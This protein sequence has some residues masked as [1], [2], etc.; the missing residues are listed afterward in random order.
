MKLYCILICLFFGTS[1]SAQNLNFIF[2]GQVTNFDTGKKE[3]GVTIEVNQ[4]GRT[5]SSSQTASNG[6][7]SAQALLPAKGNFEIIF[8]KAG[9]I[10]KKIQFNY[11][12]FD[13]SQV[14]E[15]MDYILPIRSLDMSLF[16]EKP[17]LNFSF[18]NSEPVAKFSFDQQKMIPVL[19]QPSMLS[20]KAKIEEQFN[21]AAAEANAKE[22]K[23]NNAV[24]A[25]DVLFIQDKFVEAKAKYEEALTV[26]PNEAHPKG[27][28]QEINAYVA[29]KEK[30]A[31]AQKQK[32]EA[33]KKALQEAN[34][35]RDQK[36]YNPAIAKYNE[37]LG[38]KEEQYPKD[39]IRKIEAAK[40][41]DK[42][43][44]QLEGEYKATIAAADKAMTAK[45]WAA[46]EAGYKDAQK[47][48]SSEAY[49]REQL[50]KIIKE[51][52]AEKSL[53]DQEKSYNAT[54]QSAD[55][56]F[57]SKEY[58]K[59]KTAYTQ[60]LAIKSEESYPK[61]QIEKIKEI[62]K[63]LAEQAKKDQDYLALITEG[64]KL[65]SSGSL[66]EAKSKFEEAKKLKPSESIP[67]EQITKI[68]A[69]LNQQKDLEAKEKS[70]ELAIKEGDAAFNA[71]DFSTAK[72]KYNTAISVKPEQPYPSVQLQKINDEERNLAN[73]AQKDKD[74]TDFIK[75]ADALFTQTKFQEA[76]DLYEKALLVKPNESHPKGRIEKCKEQLKKASEASDKERKMNT[77]FEEAQ[78]LINAKSYNDAKSKYKEIQS[79]DPKKNLAQVKLDEIDRLIEKE[80]KAK[81]LEEDFRRFVD[82]GD[83][84][85]KSN[86][87]AEAK[88]KYG[89]ALLLKE[90]KV[91]R[92]KYKTVEGN[93]IGEQA[94]AMVK[95]RYE[96]SIKE[97][98]DLFAANELEAAKKKYKEA[99]LFDERNPYPAQKIASIEKTISE[100]SQK[101]EK[102]D[103]AMKRGNQLMLGEKYL[104]A[105]KEFN[106][107]ITVKPDEA[108]PKEKAAE[109]ENRERTKTEEADAQFEKIL[110][111]SEKKIEEKDYDRSIEL[112]NR[113]KGSRPDDRR[114]DELLAKIT[115]LKNED[116]LYAEK[117]EAG[118]V[119]AQKKVFE[120]AIDNFEDASK[121]KPEE[122]APKERIKEVKAE[123][124]VYEEK[125]KVNNEYQK[126]F[127]KGMKYYGARNYD[128]AENFFKQ[129]L[130]AKPGD[131]PAES[132]LKEIKQILDDDARRKI[133]EQEQ[134]KAYDR[135]IKRAD[136]LF[137]QKK[138]KAAK[139]VYGQSLTID[140]SSAY[141]KRQMEECVSQMQAQSRS[142]QDAQYQK[143]V[144]A[145][146]KS[147]KEENY[148]KAVGY[149]KRALTMRGNDPYPKQKLK[150]ID[151]IL[152]P[153][154]VDSG[155]LEALGNAYEGDAD[156]E[157]ARADMMI[158]NDKNTSVL[159]VK[160]EAISQSADLSDQNY[161]KS[162][163]NSQKVFDEGVRLREINKE[164]KALR[165]G[166][167]L[168][169]ETTKDKIEQNTQMNEI[170]DRS[171]N[172]KAQE[173]LNYAH[174][175]A[176]KNLEFYQDGQL[177]KAEATKQEVLLINRD[178]E[179]RSR[180]YSESQTA[181]DQGIRKT[182]LNIE[183]SN[184]NDDAERQQTA[185]QID[186]YANEQR[187][188][189]LSLN[190]K[191]YQSSQSASSDVDDQ[192]RAN[193]Q[194]FA[195]DTK[196]AG[197]NNQEVVNT[198][199]EIIREGE[200]NKMSSDI[201]SANTIQSIDELEAR[202][203]AVNAQQVQNATEN[204]AI[205]E[206]LDAEANRQSLAILN[207]QTSSLRS[208]KRSVEDQ[209]INVENQANKYR[210]NQEANKIKVDE[211]ADEAARVQNETSRKDEYDGI[212]VQLKVDEVNR[213]IEANS[214]ISS[215]NQYAN[216][217][218]VSDLKQEAENQL[219]QLSKES[220]QI[221]K[222]QARKAADVKS[223]LSRK[224]NEETSLAQN[225]NVNLHETKNVIADGD[226]E[227]A[228]QARQQ[229]LNNRGNLNEL[230][231][232]IQ[233]EGY[234]STKK[235]EKN[236]DIL[237]DM[238]RKAANTNKD[239]QAA[240]V[241]KSQNQQ[242]AIDDVD[243]KPEIIRAK[244]SLGTEYQEGVT[245]E[246][247]SKKDS[248]GR[249][250][251]VITRRIVV[252]DGHGDVYIKSQTSNSVTY[253]KNGTSITEY[254]WQ[255]ETQGPDLQRN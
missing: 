200:L 202:L 131:E 243:T 248:R 19:D 44:E 2:G 119:A 221:N 47:L 15:G 98:D 142:E 230:E 234:R 149:Y 72:L 87:W 35:L 203:E 182:T 110:S 172:L 59:A 45:N 213:N 66:P 20:T 255:K 107:A 246:K 186:G 51:R 36:K 151:D 204:K 57:N 54:I 31:Q 37:A 126:A 147:F 252:R 183:Q 242:A 219:D 164:G 217:D 167:D 188:Q 189:L 12:N 146:D 103:A 88:E 105:I 163:S 199:R 120:K 140:I 93:M 78:V 251:S 176:E 177:E 39:E 143:I 86:S 68:D 22:E 70:Y 191:N 27:R 77:L 223:E 192:I 195:A 197:Y 159:D 101:D 69:L 64:I 152:N 239:L 65:M 40:T 8:K 148:E 111:A 229:Q 215:D 138:W 94:N 132:K 170:F 165:D 43:L 95:Q 123:K 33:Y 114:P 130:T 154:I 150:E 125:I 24:K 237:G 249:L 161:R 67:Q 254:V 134:K 153:K 25:A 226:E 79:I 32:E 23:Y 184:V 21:K 38:I 155:K 196:I 228:N 175:E 250:R 60:A 58:A 28:I 63:R 247:F 30:E 137:E 81:T 135:F 14:E 198:Q 84:L 136:D 225:N 209:Y 4:G 240:N 231:L 92:D 193:D 168:S 113:A 82:E 76:I 85:S 235:Q 118:E 233:E 141:A 104:D 96:K 17:G 18:L 73:Q 181:T 99:L 34:T 5:V 216:K 173:K 102:Y 56:A 156:A 71:K 208:D 232:T 245:E 55:I 139:D 97:A 117:M 241:S 162:Q 109:C 75:G 89:A 49:P 41:A 83:A 129:A 171:A 7:Y 52:A 190:E 174:T 220:D 194:K 207:D 1:L 115:K 205:V 185:D 236:Q 166:N 29:A 214:I 160:K 26:K 201:K 90:D 178:S 145:A 210:I 124:V 42:K 121:I 244:N 218:I 50:A 48:K 116:R 62:E 227:F 206:D 187:D 46:A 122:Q 100:A 6:K 61:A 180:N 106:K 212:N 169:L 108:E 133:A 211:I 224:A 11:S 91:V 144:D 222:Q 9:Y 16:T 238:E 10:S 13:V 157:L 179:K 127:Q 3:S 80:E 253:T 128:L 158:K 74:Y 112:L 53:A